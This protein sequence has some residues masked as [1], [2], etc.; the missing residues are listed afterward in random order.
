M[1][2]TQ[3]DILKQEINDFRSILTEKITNCNQVFLIS[4]N[5]PDF[6]SIASLGA[7]SLICKKHKKASYIIINDDYK[8][9]SEEV[10][11]MIEKVKEK[12]IVI[13]LDDYK[14]TRTDND[15]L[16]TV[17]VNQG[18]RTALDGKYK[19]FK[20][21]IIIDHHNES[22]STIKTKNKLIP[23]TVSSCS[24]IMYFLLNQYKI[25][26]SD[27]R[28]YTFLLAGIYVDNDQGK[29]IKLQSTYDVASGLCKKGADQSEVERLFSLDY[30]SDRRSQNLLDVALPVNINVMVSVS[31]DVC[32]EEE[33]SRAS[34][35]AL[36]YKCDAS[37]VAAKLEDGTFKVSARSKGHISVAN[38]M[39]ALCENGGGD[40]FKAAC[41]YKF[42][43]DNIS[44]LD[45]ANI[46][47]EEII[48]VLSYGK[49]NKN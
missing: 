10:I 30:A 14:Q 17:D 9:L 31:S 6:D 42:V 16:I 2:K 11:D 25:K 28:Y 35:Y 20:D 19:L 27:P 47:K 41:K 49:L 22:D 1:K 3:A 32:S 48:K 29:N 4:H 7:A 5:I 34:D 24:E 40:M 15:L 44:D 26:S 21:I 12:F 46:L 37:I 23:K 36:N 33:I 18:F 39:S 43:D 45:K 13:T 38:I 8:N